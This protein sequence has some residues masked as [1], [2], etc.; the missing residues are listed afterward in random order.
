TYALPIWPIAGGQ[1]QHDVGRGAESHL[2][3]EALL[4]ALAERRSL[5]RRTTIRESQLRR[6]GLHR[7]RAWQQSPLEPPA[8]PERAECAWWGSHQ[9]VHGGALRISR[10]VMRHADGSGT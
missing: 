4:V 1:H 5:V 9:A 10:N 8:P 3:R 7:A 2:V 6:S